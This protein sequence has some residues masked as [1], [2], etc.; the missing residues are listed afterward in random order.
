MVRVVCFVRTHRNL[1][2]LWHKGRKFRAITGNCQLAVPINFI[3]GISA[4]KLDC[5]RLDLVSISDEHASIISD[6]L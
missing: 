6:Y 3:R 5:F 4:R 2:F 1:V